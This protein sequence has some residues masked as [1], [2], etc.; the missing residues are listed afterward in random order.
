MQRATYS[1]LWLLSGAMALI[2]AVAVGATFSGALT[3]ASAIG[4]IPEQTLATIAVVSLL[5]GF[6]VALVAG[7]CDLAG[8]AR[9]GTALPPRRWIVGSILALPVAGPFWNL[10]V[11]QIQESISGSD[12]VRIG[13]DN[14]LYALVLTLVLPLMVGV[15]LMLRRLRPQPLAMDGPIGSRT[16]SSH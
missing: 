5:T 8:A 11:V 15:P 16:G 12:S 14:V 6:T 4:G 9:A 2:L 3:A 7:L 10:C 13:F 1:A